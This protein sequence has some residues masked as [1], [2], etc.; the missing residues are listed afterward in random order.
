MWE[1]VSTSAFV[2]WEGSGFYFYFEQNAAV[3]CPKPLNNLG[4]LEKRFC[5]GVRMFLFV[6]L[7]FLLAV[8]CGQPL[9]AQPSGLLP[10]QVP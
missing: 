8:E 1:G 3:L 9:A 7:E 5:S 4:S 10:F 2:Q 6:Y